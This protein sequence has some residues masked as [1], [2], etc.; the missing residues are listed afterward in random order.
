MESNALF[1]AFDHKDIEA[2][3]ALMTHDVRLQIGTLMS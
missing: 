2:L 3:S 1:A